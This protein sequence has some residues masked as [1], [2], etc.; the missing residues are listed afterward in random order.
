M[1][2]VGNILRMFRG[3]NTP[4]VAAA[5]PA[6][7][8]ERIARRSS[9]FA[10]FAR[11]IKT[12]DPLCILDLGP[13]SAA[14]ITHFA[15]TGGK[16]YNEDVVY[17]S[18]ESQFY[19]AGEGG[20]KVLDVER[21]MAEN[22][23]YREAMFDGVLLWDMPDYLDEPLVKPLVERL[24]QV[25]KPGGIML[26]FFHTKD[27]GPDAPYYRYHVSPNPE[28]VVLQPVW[29]AN[30]SVNSRQPLFR[31]RRV[32]ANRHIENLFRDFASLKFFLARDNVREVLA[33]R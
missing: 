23:T 15:A 2:A 22:L 28:S 16:Y 1:S 14:N 27:A 7:A 11:N 19:R 20:V 24:H 30:G 31:L 21:F 18:H 17:A 13:T 26:A 32:F 9:G 29:K 12:I 33:I 25:L 3:A 8:A 4:P 6:V 5:A 10:E